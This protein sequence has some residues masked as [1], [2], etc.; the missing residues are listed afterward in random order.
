MENTTYDYSPIISRKPFKLPNNSRI[1]VWVALC[2]E[3][4][5][6][7]KP[8]P[9]GG[10][11]HVPDMK[12]YAARDY[13]NRVGFWRIME[14]LDRYQV[15]ATLCANSEIFTHYPIIAEESKKREWEFMAHGDTNTR[16]LGELSEDEE[17][18]VIF[19]SI[20]VVT[21][22]AGVRPKGWKSSGVVTNFI[23]PSILAEAGI[24]YISDWS[25]DDQPYPVNVKTGRM[26]SLPADNVPDLRFQERT[27]A[28][29]YDTVKEHFDTLYREGVNQARTFAFCIHAFE[30]GQ[31]S[32]IG[33]LDRMLNHMKAHDGVWFCTG[34]DLAS[35][36]YEKYLG[37][38]RSQI[39]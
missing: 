10:T 14:V 18:E 25:N 38:G 21:K 23:T 24:R 6:I 37:V 17:R 7:G 31:P 33:V 27:P 39:D 12:T 5:D 35:W 2:V 1:A 11:N 20:D 28:D 16:F 4:Y 3:Y 22:T 13:G 15:K 9:G 8:V 26:I 29:Y 32:K 36:Y 19:S 30:I 34:W